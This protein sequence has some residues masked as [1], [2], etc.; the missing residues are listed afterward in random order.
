[1]NAT[2]LPLR[3]G[4]ILMC[5]GLSAFSLVQ[6]G[7]SSAE[8]SASEKKVKNNAVG[9]QTYQIRCWQEGKL[10]FEESDW[11]LTPEQ[12]RHVMVKAKTQKTEA[13]VMVVEI[14]NSLCLL[15]QVNASDIR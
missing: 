12:A 5:W 14:R 8:V 13:G 3:F 11:V 4:F 9:E 1:M 15:K 7:V 10:L 2:R 6:A